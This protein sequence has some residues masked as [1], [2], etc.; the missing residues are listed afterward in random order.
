[1]GIANGLIK[2][3]P[4]LRDL[5]F[6]ELAHNNISRYKMFT[7]LGEASVHTVGDT[8]STVNPEWEYREA[9]LAI[10]GDNIDVDQFGDFA[11]GPEQVWARVTEAKTMGVGQKFD[12]LAVYGQT[13]SIL[14]TMP[15]PTM[16]RW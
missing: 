11:A 6:A 2:V 9:T 13:T 10:L 1:M 5:P 8:W 16:P 12:K 3:S 14:A 4:W 7:S 15:V